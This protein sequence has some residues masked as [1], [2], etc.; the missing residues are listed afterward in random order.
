MTISNCTTVATTLSSTSI[1][2]GDSAHDSATL[3]NATADAGGS[4][5]YTVY[6]NNACTQGARDAGTK[7]VTNGVVPDSNSLTFPT[8][9]TFYWQA[10]YSGDANNAASKSTCT[11]E[12]LVVLRPNP[13]ISIQKG[14]DSQTV[15]K[16]AT[17]SFTI[18]VTNSGNV[19]LTNV[20]VTDALAPG[21][22]RTSTD[23]P[24]LASM[25]PGAI[26][27]YTCTLANVAASFTNSATATGTP[28]AGADVTATDT[29]N[30]TVINPA[31]SIAKTPDTQTIV[32][33]TTATFTIKVTNSG[34]ATLTNVVVTDALAPGCARTQVGVPALA[35]MAPGGDRRYT[36]T[37]AN[38]TA[39]FT[40]RPTRAAR[41]RSAR[42]SRRATPPT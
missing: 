19:T 34:D 40:N 18:S 7:T 23:I 36:C 1:F 15:L 28:P 29:A 20:R 27:T 12:Q 24:A 30:V 17:A 32:A 38:V 13:K 14:P 6:S 37:L 5:T 8:P 3:G 11:D 22:A 42:P 16:G 41:L 25:A 31:I 10:S 9:G 33:G 39:S 26:V 21:C 4:V 2:A 35:S